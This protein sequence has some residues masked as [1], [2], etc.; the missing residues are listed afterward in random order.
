MRKVSET[1]ETSERD[2]TDWSERDKTDCQWVK[3]ARQARARVRE[4]AREIRLIMSEEIEQKRDKQIARISTLYKVVTTDMKFW[5]HHSSR[6]NS[7]INF[8]ERILII[9][10][11]I[12][13]V[14]PWDKANS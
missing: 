5:I 4:W 14:W 8:I 6:L 9:T 3:E 11:P 1:S 13:H 10:C 12:D 2:K 7:N